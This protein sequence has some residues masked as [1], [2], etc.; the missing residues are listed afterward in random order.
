[1]FSPA[2]DSHRVLEGSLHVARAALER[3]REDDAP[4]REVGLVGVGHL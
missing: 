4:P 3:R 1:M 2:D